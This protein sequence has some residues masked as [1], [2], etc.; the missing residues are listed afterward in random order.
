[1]PKDSGSKRRKIWDVPEDVEK[2]PAGPRTPTNDKVSRIFDHLA[3]AGKSDKF[4][5]EHSKSVLEFL[6]SVKFKDSFDILDVGCGSGWTVR[7]FAGM[8]SCRKAVG[9]D[10]SPGMIREAESKKSSSR[11]KYK[12]TDIESFRGGK[13]D[14]VFSMEALYFA[15]SAEAAISKIYA[16]L[17]P[18]GKFFCGIDFYAENKHT[19]RWAGM[20]SIKLNLHSRSEWR[21]FFKDVG[22]ADIKTRQ[23]KD[24]GSRQVWRRE[25]GTL[26]ISG[27]R[28]GALTGTP[29]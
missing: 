4:E 3:D 1:M 25:H 14:Y 6:K 16:H 18:G 2:V 29:E 11:E 26:F 15:E 22:F 9:I 17:K 23:I 24:P 5:R 13:F 19:R 8:S 27:T 12:A 28:P 21:R 7:H 20:V 10:K